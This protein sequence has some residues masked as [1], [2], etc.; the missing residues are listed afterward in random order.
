MSLIE[1]CSTDG[2]WRSRQSITRVDRSR[3][4]GNTS[5][6]TLPIE[7]IQDRIAAG[8]TKHTKEGYRPPQPRKVFIV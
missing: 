3:K 6:R 5:R 1:F 2:G 8:L 4:Y 7:E